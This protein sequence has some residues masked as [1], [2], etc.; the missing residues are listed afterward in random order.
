MHEKELAVEI[1]RCADD[2][3]Q[4]GWVEAEIVDVEV[5]IREVHDA[6]S[7]RVRKR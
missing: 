3:H 7:Q 6:P 5:T 1:V 4:P 2:H